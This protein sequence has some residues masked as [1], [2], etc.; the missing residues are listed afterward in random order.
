MS[1][2]RNNELINKVNEIINNLSNEQDKET[3]KS[4]IRAYEE[5]TYKEYSDRYKFNNE[6][7]SDMI[8]DFGFSEK[9]TA[10]F[11][12]NEHPTLQ[13]TFMRLACKFIGEMADKTYTDGRNEASVNLARKIKP[14][15]VENGGLPM[16]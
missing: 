6:A 2:K 8:N 16:V 9:D 3:I 5:V 14:I 11:M 12:A 13:Q 10:K 4:L 1:N 7:L 15:L